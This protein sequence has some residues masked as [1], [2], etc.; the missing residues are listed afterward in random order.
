[1]SELITIGTTPTDILEIMKCVKNWIKHRESAIN[2]TYNKQLRDYEAG[3]S[4]KMPNP[5]KVN[6]KNE[7]LKYLVEEYDKIGMKPEPP[8]PP[9]VKQIKGLPIVRKDL[10]SQIQINSVLLTIQQPSPTRTLQMPVTNN[11]PLANSLLITQD[12]EYK[13]ANV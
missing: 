1:M 12:I 6:M 11:L 8:R 9:I 2:C 4:S 13:N 10:P 7:R 3:K 5:P